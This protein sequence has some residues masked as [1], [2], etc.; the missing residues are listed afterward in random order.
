MGRIEKLQFALRK[1]LQQSRSWIL[2]T[3]YIL[4]LYSYLHAGAYPLAQ[5]NLFP[6]QRKRELLQRPCRR[7]FQG[8]GISKWPVMGNTKTT[9]YSKPCHLL[10]LEKKKAETGKELNLQVRDVFS[11]ELLLRS[12]PD[13]ADQTVKKCLG[14]HFPKELCLPAAFSPGKGGAVKAALRPMGRERDSRLVSRSFSLPP[15]PLSWSPP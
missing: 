6:H 10:S 4:F 12:L 7:Q 14:P 13:S 11:Q 9:K 8:A 3:L 15:T 2:H 5:E 1:G